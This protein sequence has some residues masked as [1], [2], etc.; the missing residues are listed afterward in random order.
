MKKGYKK[1]K[2]EFI[3]LFAGIGG[4]RIG[5]EKACRDLKLEN[6]CVFSSEWDEACQKSYNALF[7]HRPEGDITK[8]SIKNKIPKKFDILLAGFPCQPFSS[9]GG[10]E[11][12][13]NKAQG[14]L[15]YHIAD[16]LKNKKPAMFLLENVVGLKTH[17]NKKGEKTI[18]IIIKILENDLD[19]HVFMEVLNASDFGVPQDRK[20]IYIVGFSKKLWPQ[21][22][23]IGFDFNK[24]RKKSTVYINKFLEKGGSARSITKHLQRVY[25]NKK[26]D[27][28]PQILKFNGKQI[29]KTLVAS[30]HKIQRLT[31]IFVED[32]PTGLRLLTEKECRAIMGFPF[33]LP[34]LPVS[35]TQQY[36]QYGNSVVVPV[37]RKISGQMLKIY[38]R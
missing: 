34:S 29:S 31:G 30:Y 4:T 17:K 26:K 19:Y 5:L 12:F 21:K 15:F 32:G 38:F 11:G 36:R 33:D 22:D 10:R 18:D 28:R 23:I 13:N 9:I 6:K 37:I 35:S 16:I 24:L 20:R 14:S 7:G 1:N 3:D 8:Q 2:I 27:G 25:I